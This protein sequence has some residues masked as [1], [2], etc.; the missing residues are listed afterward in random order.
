MLIREQALDW[1]VVLNKRQFLQGMAITGALLALGASSD[2][3][4]IKYK[5]GF[6]PL[7]N[8]VTFD[9]ISPYSRPGTV[10]YSYP[11]TLSRIKHLLGPAYNV[12]VYEIIREFGLQAFS[13]DVFK[14][15]VGTKYAE[16]G[17]VA[18]GMLAFAPHGHSVT[19]CQRAFCEGF[20]YDFIPQAFP[21]QDGLTIQDFHS[22][23]GLGNPSVLLHMSSEPVKRKLEAL[24][25]LDIVN[26]SLQFGTLAITHKRRKV[27]TKID[28]TTYQNLSHSLLTFYKNEGGSDYLFYNPDSFFIDQENEPVLRSIVTG[29]A[30]GIEDYTVVPAVDYEQYTYNKRKEILE[31]TLKVEEV[32]TSKSPF[33]EIQGAYTGEY[34]K[35][36]VQELFSLVR[37]FPEKLFIVAAGNYGDDLE[38]LRNIF[39]EEWP[40]NLIIAGYWDSELQ[41][42]RM[43]NTYDIFGADIYV[44]PLAYAH[45]SGSSMSTAVLSAAASILAH[46]GVPIAQIK[47]MLLLC[48][49]DIEIEKKSSIPMESRNIDDYI[50]AEL[51]KKRQIVKVFNPSQFKLILDNL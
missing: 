24:P 30:V 29:E 20:G 50:Y 34:G 22:V 44:D 35:D 4:E 41:Y 6:I 49:E 7:S 27:Q 47:E 33:Y 25:H 17:A 51:N 39:S 1:N 15:Q 5:E 31:S 11:E 28:D 14:K 8:T 2:I 36:N 42:P 26:I 38:P 21:I 40:Q 9:F 32:D 18:G 19:N 46:K 45:E 23:D 3:N 43:Y 13:E 48:C 12:P 10:R 16:Y 37:S